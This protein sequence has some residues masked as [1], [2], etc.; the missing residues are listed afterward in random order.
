MVSIIIAS[1]L[2]NQGFSWLLNVTIKQC[3]INQSEMP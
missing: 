3:D 2:E 1:S